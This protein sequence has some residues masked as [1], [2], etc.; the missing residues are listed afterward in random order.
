M[1]IFQ[2]NESY[3]V[4]IKTFDDHHKQLIK[5]VNQLYDAMAEG[6]GRQELRTIL[7]SLIQYTNFHF[8]SEE[9]EML[10]FRYP[11]YIKHRAEH[12]LLKTQVTEYQAKMENGQL[13]LS[14]EVASFLKNWLMNHILGEDKKYEPYLK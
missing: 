13:G 7:D 5:L 10:K 3:S 6:K 8:A 9:K 4:G 12:T 14:I 2:W 11:G 1:P